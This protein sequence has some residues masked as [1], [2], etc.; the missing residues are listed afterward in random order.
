MGNAILIGIIVF[1]VA[2]TFAGYQRGLIKTIFS[3]LSMIIVLVLVTVLTP[4]TEGII[5]QTS[6]Y[7]YIQDTVRD[8]VE[9]SVNKQL[10]NNVIMGIGE[11]EQNK[12]IDN[13]PV[14]Q[15]IKDSLT[16]NNTESGYKEFKVSNFV[17]YIVESIT[18]T[19]LNAISFIILFILITIAVRVAVYLLDIVAKLPVLSLFNH[20]GGAIAGFFEA[21][22]IIWTLCIIITAFGAT[23]WGREIFDII[24]NNILLSLIYNN[25][26]LE[27]VLFGK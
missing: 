19:I 2:M 18:D 5:K 20:G 24:N 1:L 6:M 8:Y 10:G 3:L 23:T 26:I 9:E 12:V 27:A 11:G 17:D 13:L 14:P 4:A 16:K 21:M 25:N 15:N 7:S 22:A